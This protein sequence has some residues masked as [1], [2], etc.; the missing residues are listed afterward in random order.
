MHFLLQK[1]L[2]AS[3]FLGRLISFLSLVIFAGLLQ[4]WIRIIV[5]TAK[6]LPI[7]PREILGCGGLFFFATTLCVSSGI[8]LHNKHPMKIGSV[9]FNATLAV[10]GIAFC[11]AIYYA[12]VLTTVGMKPVIPFG[13]ETIPQIGFVSIALIYWFYAGLRTKLFTWDESSDA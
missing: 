5:T 12:S 10:H 1:L 13:K 7:E 3:H 2:D 9:D 8:Y 6:N 4:V 11:T